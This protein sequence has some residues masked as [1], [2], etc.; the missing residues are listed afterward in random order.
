MKSE[1]ERMDADESNFVND[2]PAIWWLHFLCE[3]E[4]EI[5]LQKP[6]FLAKGSRQ[7]F[8]SLL[9]QPAGLKLLAAAKPRAAAMQMMPS[10]DASTTTNANI[11][12]ILALPRARELREAAELQAHTDFTFPQLKWSGSS[13]PARKKRAREC[14]EFGQQSVHTS[15][16]SLGCIC[17]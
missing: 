14:P 5:V 3:V 2:R 13:N 10:T 4:S 1:Q 11:T 12:G 7:Y 6:A 17:L 9:L 16:L 8:S 15:V